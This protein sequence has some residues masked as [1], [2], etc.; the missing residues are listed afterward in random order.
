[1]DENTNI[2]TPV[3]KKSFNKPNY[4][5]QDGKVVSVMAHTILDNGNKVFVPYKFTLPLERSLYKLYN[6]QEILKEDLSQFGEYE[7]SILKNFIFAKHNYG[8]NSDFYQAYFNLFEFYNDEKKRASRTKNMDGL[9]TEADT[10][11]LE[12]INKAL[13]K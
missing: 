2:V 13:K 7:L 1:M 10:R 3:V 11:N 5:Y 4:N 9:L 12:V 8:F 6:D